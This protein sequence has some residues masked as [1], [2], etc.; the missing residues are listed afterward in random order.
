MAIKKIYFSAPSEKCSFPRANAINDKKTI[1]S[2]SGGQNYDLIWG[3]TALGHKEPTV[4]RSRQSDG[5]NVVL[6]LSL[7]SLFP[8][9]E[10]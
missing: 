2:G 5:V 3:G 4:R 8:E 1:I 6:F 9:A 10:K 7:K